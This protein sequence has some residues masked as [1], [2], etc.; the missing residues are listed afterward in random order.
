MDIVYAPSEPMGSDRAELERE[1]FYDLLYLLRGLEECEPDGELH[2]TLAADGLADSGEGTVHPWR[3]LLL[4]PARVAPREFP[5]LTCRVV[6][7]NT[8]EDGSVAGLLTEMGRPADRTAARWS[9]WPAGRRGPDRSR[10]SPSVRPTRGPWIQ[11][12]RT[13]SREGWADSGTRWP[14]NS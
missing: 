8:T 13:S 9:P 3:G 6:D 1:N 7:L 5:H 10:A 2:L 12:R 14:R 11:G 4:G